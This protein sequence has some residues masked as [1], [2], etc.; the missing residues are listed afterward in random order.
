ML[1]SYRSLLRRLA[2]AAAVM[3][4]TWLMVP[5][6]AQADSVRLPTGE[7]PA[8][9]CVTKGDT[10]GDELKAVRAA[11]DLLAYSTG[12]KHGHVR[13]CNSKDEADLGATCDELAAA[14]GCITPHHRLWCCLGTGND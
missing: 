5:S 14:E 6:V 10:Q 4:G 13:P 3:L 9:Q 8:S 11:C 2:L 12:F 7:S 1:K